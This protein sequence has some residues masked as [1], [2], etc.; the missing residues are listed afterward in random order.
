MPAIYLFIALTSKGISNKDTPTLFGHSNNIL[1]SLW[2]LCV[3][4]LKC[5]HRIRQRSALSCLPCAWLNCSLHHHTPC[6]MKQL[7]Y[8]ANHPAQQLIPSPIGHEQ[9]VESFYLLTPSPHA[10]MKQRWPQSAHQ[11][12]LRPIA[13]YIHLLSM[14]MSPQSHE[15]YEPGSLLYSKAQWTL[16][17][18]WNAFKLQFSPPER[19]STVLVSD[20]IKIRT[21]Q[22]KQSFASMRSLH[23]NKP[24]FA[25]KTWLTERPPWQQSRQFRQY[26]LWAQELSHSQGLFPEGYPEA[27]PIHLHV[28]S[29]LVA[30]ICPYSFRWP[31]AY[32][33]WTLDGTERI[34][35]CTK[36]CNTSKAHGQLQLLTQNTRHLKRK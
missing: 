7:L 28:L 13:G 32:L 19:Y 26:M 18:S 35:S 23:T 25:M 12:D 11:R 4:S 31:W 20:M 3:Q 22:P 6:L 34:S 16:A 36:I 29:S 9:A 14:L 8:M 27:L 10:C 17:L 2:S 15:S 33:W 1:Q 5:S 30:C 21:Q 24:T